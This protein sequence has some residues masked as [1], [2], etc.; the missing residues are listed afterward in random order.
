[1]CQQKWEEREGLGSETQ[2]FVWASSTHLH[3]FNPQQTNKKQPSSPD[4]ISCTPVSLVCKESQV[5]GAEAEESFKGDPT[6]V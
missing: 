6:W 3:S 4:T 2:K 1:M 5:A